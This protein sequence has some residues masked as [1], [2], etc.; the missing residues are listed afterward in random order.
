MLLDEENGQDPN[1]RFVLITADHRLFDA[2]SKWFWSGEGPNDKGRFLLRLPLQYVPLLNILEMPN[3]IESSDIIK[4]AR[5]A[6]D[7]PFI[8]LRRT[9]PGYPHTLSLHRILSRFS[10]EFPQYHDYL[11]KFYGF[12]PLTLGHEGVELFRETRRDWEKIYENCVVLNTELIE[13]RT[14]ANLE[15]ISR[16]LP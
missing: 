16:I 14:R 7:S 4:R 1:V 9:D 11:V 12:N 15:R 10:S 2:Y 3:G 5:V 6:L 13:H 8:N